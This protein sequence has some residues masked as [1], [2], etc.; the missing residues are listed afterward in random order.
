MIQM[1]LVIPMITEIKKKQINQT[2][3]NPDKRLR[4]NTNIQT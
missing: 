1:I 3:H 2:N 4:S